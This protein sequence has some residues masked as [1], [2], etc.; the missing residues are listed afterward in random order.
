MNVGLVLGGG[1][2]RGIAHIGVVKALEERSIKPVAISGCSM[3][4]IIG[5]FYAHGYSS[6]QMLDVV[7]NLKYRQFLHLGELGGLV[8]GLGLE[9]V[10]SKHLPETFK[11]LNLP[12]SVT[13]VD[14]QAGHLMVIRSGKLVIALRASSALPGILSPVKHQGRY[15]VDGG[16]LNNLP[17][18]IIRSMTL[19]PVIAVDVAAPPNRSLEFEPD[20]PN[21]LQSFTDMVTGKKN[22]IDDLFSRGLTI[23]LFMKA[24]DIPQK[25]ITEMRLS[26]Q[27][28][29]VLIRP[30]IDPQLGIEDFAEYETL[31][32][33]GYQAASQEL[34]RWLNKQQTPAKQPPKALKQSKQ[35]KL[36]P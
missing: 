35:K 23:E 9:K 29:E 20:K 12:L 32:D 7:Q 34:D 17:V 2:A 8:G 25:V 31:I 6:E 3:G 28:P 1:G 33:A 13:T 4:A 21:L 18:D 27:P 10:L 15:L 16:L 14:V 11:D 30:D 36:E 24:F 5:A 22:P 26:L 19:E